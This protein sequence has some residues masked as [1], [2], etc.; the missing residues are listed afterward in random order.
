MGRQNLVLKQRFGQ[1]PIWFYLVLSTTV[2]LLLRL[3]GL[4]RLS[5]WFDEAC[6]TWRIHQPFAQIPFHNQVDSVPFL[7]YYLL[8]CW[9]W[10]WS[11]TDFS[12]RLF[13]AL[14]GT[15]AISVVFALGNSLFDPPT[16][17]LASLLLALSSYHIQYS[18]EARC[19]AL[20]TVLF[21]LTW[22]FLSKALRDRKASHW[23]GYVL[24]GIFLIY[25][26]GVSILY[27]TL[28][29]LTVLI[30]G[31]NWT[32]GIWK[33]WLVANVVVF[34]SFLPWLPFYLVQ[35]SSFHSTTELPRPSL[36]HVINTLILL[37]SLPPSSTQLLPRA[38][39]KLPVLLPVIQIIWFI[40]ISFLL[41]VPGA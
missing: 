31:R 16:G 22:Y 15:A 3:H 13:S 23:L 30:S 26:H 12:L 14:L 1:L 39:S 19:Y 7:Y 32:I 18:Q 11:D 40:S 2:G 37:G 21:G 27:L 33:R 4:E 41:L 36:S 24:C 29:N 8:K 35:V 38:F 5:F 10:I 17:V 6:T 9:T 25:C 20:L 34:S 28:V